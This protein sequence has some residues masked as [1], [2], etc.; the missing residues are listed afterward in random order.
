MSRTGDG[1]CGCALGQLVVLMM[2]AI[3]SLLCSSSS[4]PAPQFIRQPLAKSV[5]KSAPRQTAAT[6][7][8]T[9][10]QQQQQAFFYLKLHKVI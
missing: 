4:V 2:S 6:S 5:A 8:A 9:Q 3:N 10:Q 1:D 7:A